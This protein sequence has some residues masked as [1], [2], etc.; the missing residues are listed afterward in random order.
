MASEQYLDCE[1]YL[2]SRDQARLSID[3]RDYSGRP[4][5]DDELERRLLEAELEPSRYGTLL[6]EALLPL[7]G[8][9]H[10]GYLEALAQARQEARRLRLRLHVAPFAPEQLHDLDWERLYDPR[11]NMALGRSQETALVRYLSVATRSLEAIVDP[12]RMLVAVASPSDLEEYGL[13]ELDGGA[14]RTR[15]DEALAPLRERM[16]CEFLEGPATVGRIRERLVG[17]GFHVLHLQAHGA[18]R[19]GAPAAHLVL[20]DDDGRARFVDADLLADV[21]GERGLRLVT[22]MACHGGERAGPEAFGGLAPALVRRGIPAVVAMRRTVTVEGAARFVEHFYANLA[23]DGRVDAAVNEARQQLYLARPEGLEWSTPALFLRL[24]DGR[25]W[26]GDPVFRPGKRKKRSFTASLRRASARWARIGTAAVVVSLIVGLWLAF[27][28]PTPFVLWRGER[29]PSADTQLEIVRRA[30]EL[31][32]GRG[33]PAHLAR[34]WVMEGQA[35]SLLNRHEEA[36]SALE[37]AL[38][39]C[40]RE[41]IDRCIADASLDLGNSLWHAQDLTAALSYYRNARGKYVEIGNETAE[42]QAIINMALIHQNL[43]DLDVGAELLDDAISIVAGKHPA[44]EIFSRVNRMFPLIE[45]GRFDDALEEDEAVDLLLASSR[46]ASLRWREAEAF[47]L[48]NRG[49][50]L[51]QTG[52]F[53]D[54]RALLSRTKKQCEDQNLRTFHRHAV[55]YLAGVQAHQGDL[56]EAKRGYESLVDVR[57]DGERSA[58]GDIW[59]KLGDVHRLAGDLE[60]AEEIYAR[61]LAVLATPS[62]DPELFKTR[63]SLAELE[64]ARGRP[65]AAWKHLGSALDYFEPRQFHL[66]LLRG[67][68]LKARIGLA[69]GH[70]EAA[71][72]AIE[73]ARD[74]L[75]A[76]PSHTYRVPMAITAARIRA[77]E[78]PAGARERLA[79]IIEEAQKGLDRRWELEARFAA[80]GRRTLRR[81]EDEAGRNGLGLLARRA[82]DLLAGT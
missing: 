62:G 16:S 50:L 46:D 36:R 75:V 5:L 77:R 80:E 14:M 65:E 69:Q 52:K 67:Y 24:A 4:R 11:R 19:Q 78:D 54:A 47:A 8:E 30:K 38:A 34:A 40:R 28:P 17:G 58:S 49:Y 27:L 53:A 37:E 39:F 45:M 42:A 70:L 79:R 56:A 48:V 43:G 33:Q 71:E 35:L 6:F 22:L 66:M 20:E 44:L 31:A 82:A 13:P 2:T 12:P 9:L 63:L 73:A 10:T 68:E 3:G 25:L 1:F 64:L 18:L 74:L 81:V 51:F 76:Y 29:A 32:R 61:A 7:G 21:L 41:E 57:D 55:F 59:R 72:T 60:A 23:R 15:L 26:Q